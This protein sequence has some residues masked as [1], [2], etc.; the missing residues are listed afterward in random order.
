MNDTMGGETEDARRCGSGP[1]ATAEAVWEMAA[2]AVTVA[3][4]PTLSS[5]EARRA[6]DNENGAGEN[7][8]LLVGDRGDEIDKSIS[9]IE[10]E[11]LG[12]CI[13]SPA[14]LDLLSR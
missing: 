8:L 1:E 14:I 12:D 11:V 2:A 4:G 13:A 9:S 7:E 5:V 10:V 6:A 3:I